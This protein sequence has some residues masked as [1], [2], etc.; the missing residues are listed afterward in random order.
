M[1]R[2]DFFEKKEEILADT[3]ALYNGDRLLFTENGTD[4]K[5]SI[6]FTEKEIILERKADVAS[7]TVLRHDH[8]CSEV[9]SPYGK[10]RLDAKLLAE[11]K[12]DTAWMCEYQILSG[13]EIVTYQR[14]LFYILP[15]E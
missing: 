1:I 2:Y 3:T 9:V 10:M 12:S 11:K 5:L 13:K 7:R 6:T 8:S 15:Q 4:A 14:L